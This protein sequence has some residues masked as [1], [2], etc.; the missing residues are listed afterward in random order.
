MSPVKQKAVHY[1]QMSVCNVY[2]N[3][4]LY[5]FLLPAGTV[6]SLGDKHSR[7]QKT[8]HHLQKS[9]DVD[10]TNGQT[11]HLLGK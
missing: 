3:G 8:V 6:E 4:H 5:C 2:I 1:L 10:S 11:W 9:I 7:E